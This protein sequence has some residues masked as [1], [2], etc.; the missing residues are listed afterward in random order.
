ML[1][2]HLDAKKNK[3]SWIKKILKNL[4]DNQLQNSTIKMQNIVKLHKKNKFKS[5]NELNTKE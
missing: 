3:M 5:C 1:V 4:E 2:K